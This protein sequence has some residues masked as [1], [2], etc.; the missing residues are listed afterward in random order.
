MVSQ[1]AE[2]M[3]IM[4]IM[5]NTEKFSHGDTETQSAPFLYVSAESKPVLR[6]SL[7]LWLTLLCVVNDLSALHG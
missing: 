5:E 7:S 3:E 1:H 2:I 4:E 6:V